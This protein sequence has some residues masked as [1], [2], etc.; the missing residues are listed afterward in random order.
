MAAKKK[1]AKKKAAA[2][3]AAGGKKKDVK[4][5]EKAIQTLD[6]LEHI[7]LRTGMYIGRLGDGTNPVDG[8]YVMMKEVI[9]NSIDEFIMGEGKKIDITRDGV[10]LSLRADDWA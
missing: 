2:K 7:R 3:P 8:I 9:D 6:A 4:Y 5:D 1:A 10:T